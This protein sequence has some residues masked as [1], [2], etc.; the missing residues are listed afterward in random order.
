MQKT[1]KRR[2]KSRQKNAKRGRIGEKVA[3]KEEWRSQ[4]GKVGEK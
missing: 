2:P 4:K 1:S 3:R